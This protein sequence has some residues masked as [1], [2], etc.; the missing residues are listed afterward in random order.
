MQRSIWCLSLL[1]IYL[2]IFLVGTK[3]ALRKEMDEVT[4][5]LGQTATLKCQIIGRPVPE[6]K[7][8]KGGKE[9]K[10]GRKYA[11]T[12]DGRNHTLT[13]S[14]DQQEDEGLYTCKAVNEAGECETSGTLVLEAAPQ[15]PVPLKDKFF[16]TCGS[17]VRIHAVYI[18]RP[19]PKIM[20]LYGAKALEPSENVIIENTEHYTHLILKNSRKK[21]LKT[22]RKFEIVTQRPFTLDHAPRVT[23]RM[24]SHR[25]PIGQNTKFTM[26][27]QSKPE[28]QIKWYH[29]GLQIE[30]S[31]KYR[32]FNMS[33][34]LSLQIIDCQEEDSG[35]YRVV[36][37]NAKGEASDYAT[38]DVAGGGFS[39]YASQRKDEE[40][41]TPFVPEMTKTDYTHVQP[42]AVLDLL[43][44]TALL[45]FKVL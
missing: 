13:I 30:E 22:E 37:T 43:L 12:S 44:Q 19:Q 40:P 27:V 25:V 33:G 45:P 9:I 28:A 5:K 31:R 42:K 35:T 18:G 34:V 36:C 29:N 1:F 26:N 23:V 32:I 7:W 17:T 11:A 4:A 8:Y 14:T 16:A 21:A 20:W 24:R 41:P 2:F 6:I 38:L 3:P 39:A 15:F 10:E